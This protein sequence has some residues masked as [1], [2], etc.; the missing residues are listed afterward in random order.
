M[1]FKKLDLG[2]FSGCISPYL[3][4]PIK[5]AISIDYIDGSFW[6]TYIEDDYEI[7]HSTTIDILNTECDSLTFSNSRLL[8][9]YTYQGVVYAVFERIY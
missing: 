6:L 7:Q 8:G 2:L 1:N 3:G 5:Q 9:S 4:K